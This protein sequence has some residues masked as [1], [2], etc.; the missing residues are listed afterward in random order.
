MDQFCGSRAVL[1]GP[2][3]GVVGYAITSY[4]QMEKKPVIGFDMGGTSTDVSRYAGQYEHVFEATTAGVTL[5]APQLDINTG[6]LWLDQSLQE[7]IQDPPATEKVTHCCGPLTVTDANLALGRLL[8]SFFPKIFGPGE[9]EALSSEETMKHFHRLSKEINLFLTN[10][11]NGSGSE[12]SVEEVAMGFIRVANEA[13]CRP[14]RAL[15]QAKGHDTSQHVYS[16]VLSAYGLALADVVEE[17][18]EPC[19][20]Q[21]EQQAF[22]DL[23]RRVEQ[24][25]ERCRETLYCA[26]MVTA[27]GHPANPQSCAAGDFRSAFT[28]RYL[29]EF[30]FTIPDRPIMVDD[31][32]VRGCG[33]SGIKSVYKTK[34]GRGQAKPV[35]MTKCYFEEGYLD[36]GVYLWE[37]LPSTPSWWSRAVRPV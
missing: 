33:K 10:G 6:C 12:M 27:D 22:R 31:I 13:M 23:N 36:T 35:T 25:S 21:Y 1:S 14:I 20:L 30:G 37:E 29:K 11:A 3:G 24:L 8:P 26:L 34:T 7:L 5:Q 2:A 28:K 17:E 4:N 16:G 32:R 15:T 9:N 19:S 18:Q